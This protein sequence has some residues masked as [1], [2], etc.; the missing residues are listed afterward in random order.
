MPN[1]KA[2][3]TIGSTRSILLNALPGRLA[4]RL[5]LSD[6]DYIE[7]NLST[8]FIHN[9][10]SKVNL[11]IKFNID[12]TEKDDDAIK[13]LTKIQKRL[14]AIKYEHDD[15]LKQHAVETIGCGCP[16]PA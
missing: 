11:E 16:L 2:K 9:L 7:K 3:I 1:T 6:L 13:H 12:L 8:E 15:F 5:S 4:T 14:N 10:V